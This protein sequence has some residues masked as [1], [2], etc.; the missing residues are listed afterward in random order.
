MGFREGAI[1]WCWE[2]QPK[3]D[4]W[5]KLRISINRKNKETDEYET[6]FGGW[7][8]CFGTAVAAKA[9][10]LKAKDRIRLKSVDLTQNY[11][12]ENKIMYWNPKIFDFEM[13]DDADTEGEVKK[14]PVKSKA[15]RAYEGDND[16][17][18]DDGGLP[19]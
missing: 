9:A 2:I 1:C 18:E 5:T 17:D 11:D 8:D 3:G 6:E 12:K 7:V 13:A 14:A 15:S 4:N 19:F 10:K 16:V